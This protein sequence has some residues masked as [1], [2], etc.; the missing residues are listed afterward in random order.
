MLC[1]GCCVLVVIVCLL[2]DVSLC[3]VLVVVV[4]AN[5]CLLVDVSLCCILVVVWWWLCLTCGLMIRCVVCRLLCGC[6]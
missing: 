1:A 6:G 5:V 4:V 3:C 2:I